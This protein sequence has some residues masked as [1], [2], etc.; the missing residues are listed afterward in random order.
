DRV[1]WKD[2]VGIER[3]GTG[4][5]AP[6]PAQAEPVWLSNAHAASHLAGSFRG[7]R[8]GKRFLESGPPSGGKDCIDVFDARGVV[9]V[10]R[11]ASVRRRNHKEL[12][13][14]DGIG[15]ARIG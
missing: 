6:D 11:A 7:R 5:G 14:T 1:Y 12:A 10:Q 15:P 13:G 2:V 3:R 8:F 4:V 9:Q